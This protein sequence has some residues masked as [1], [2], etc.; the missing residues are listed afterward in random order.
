MF[1]PVR[2]LD[3]DIA[4][5]DET[6]GGS[7]PVD[8]RTQLHAVWINLLK[9]A[10]PAVV[11]S[12]ARHWCDERGAAAVLRADM[13]CQ[14]PESLRLVV[15]SGSLAD[16]DD[17]GA[18]D[19]YRGAAVCEGRSP[20]DCFRAECGDRSPTE[21]REARCKVRPVPRSANLCLP[22]EQWT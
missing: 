13:V 19:A 10:R 1:S 16:A 6:D 11:E 22:P 15:C 14:T 12:F 2:A 3:C 18:P 5:F 17:D 7:R 4:F 8:L 9:R 21:C 20:A